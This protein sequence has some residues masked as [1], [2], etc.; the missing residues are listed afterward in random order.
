MR[1][2]CAAFSV[3]RESDRNGNTGLFV[4]RYS[5]A[6]ARHFPYLANLVEMEPMGCVCFGILQR[7]LGVRSIFR[8]SRVRQKC[9]QWLFVLRYSAVCARRVQHFSYVASLTKNGT[10]GL[11]VLRYSGVCARCVRVQHFPYV[12]SLTEMGP[13]GCLCSGI[14]CSVR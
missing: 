11:L 3:C 4:L 12:A 2:V 9:D 13:M 10:N 7:A 8:M 6:C 5:A 1:Y 14:C